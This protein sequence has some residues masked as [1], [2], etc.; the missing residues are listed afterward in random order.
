MCDAGGF[1]G[2][3]K[4]AAGSLVQ[5]DRHTQFW[6]AAAPHDSA[7]KPVWQY[8]AEPMRHCM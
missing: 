6:R 8:L 5:V 1:L 3:P 7:V 2:V 4:A